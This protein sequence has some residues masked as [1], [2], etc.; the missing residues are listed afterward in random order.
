MM[1]LQLAVSLVSFGLRKFVNCSNETEKRKRIERT[2][3]QRGKIHVFLYG[4]RKY[5]EMSFESQFYLCEGVCF[6]ALQLLLMISAVCAST[7]QTVFR[8]IKSSRM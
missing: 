6:K 7:K 3:R 2:N 4:K 8:L 5:I 1:I